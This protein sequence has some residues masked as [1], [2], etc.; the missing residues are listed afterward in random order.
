MWIIGRPSLK[1]L[2]AALIMSAVVA[3]VASN[4]SLREPQYAP[5]VRLFCIGRVQRVDP[6]NVGA[7][8][9]RLGKVMASKTATPG[10]S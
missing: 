3:V 2:G 8:R 5:Q 7:E 4:D 6:T 1:A 9:R 10:Q